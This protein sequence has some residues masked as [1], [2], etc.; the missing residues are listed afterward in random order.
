M[1]KVLKLD[2][3]WSIHQWSNAEAKREGYYCYDIWH[4][5]GDKYANSLCSGSICY[6]CHKVVPDGIQ[7]FLVLCRSDLGIA[8]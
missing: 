2:D 8:P 7:G 1:I 5:C 4:Q 3:E 6:R